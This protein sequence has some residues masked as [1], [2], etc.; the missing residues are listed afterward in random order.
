M[1][2]W[3]NLQNTGAVKASETKPTEMGFWVEATEQ[4][5][6]RF[7]M[8]VSYAVACLEKAVNYKKRVLRVE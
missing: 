8:Q 2:Y 6:I 5:Y 4:D 7:Q 1:K 3:K